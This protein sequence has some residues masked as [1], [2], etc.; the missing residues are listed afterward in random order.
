[1]KYEKESF[2]LE[3]TLECG[4]CFRWNRQEDGSYKGVASGRCLT[5]SQ[6]NLEQV[7]DDPFW[8]NYFDLALD[9][10]K[11]RTEFAAFDPI[12][13]KAAGYAPGMRILNQEP[14][15]ALAS[16]ILS[17][18]NNIKRIKGIVARL[19][20]EFGDEIGGERA[21]PGAK[22]LAVL[23]EGDLGGIRCGFR[24]KYLLDAAK[25]TAAGEIDFQELK[26]LPFEEAQAKLMTISGVGPK[27]ADCVLLYGLHRLE[28]FPMDVWMKR[29]MAA[30]FPGKDPAYFGPYAG[31]AQQYIFH[32]SRN[33]PQLFQESAE[34][35][36]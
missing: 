21:F 1:M 29:A 6:S 31:I 20:E 11:I 3:Q 35:C 34:L 30:L 33:N 4:Q 12:L 28:A 26:Q 14:W 7:L 23:E 8:R 27:V 18:N 25:K 13:A 36:G 22:T 17:Q 16:F 32:Y 15:E 10:G 9:Y 24:A 19:C 2:D 5:I